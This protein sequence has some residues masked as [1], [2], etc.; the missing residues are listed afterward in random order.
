MLIGWTSVSSDWSAESTVSDSLSDLGLFFFVR[1]GFAFGSGF[2][3]FAVFRDF[4]SLGRFLDETVS[5]TD[6]LALK[7]IIKRVYDMAKN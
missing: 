1:F 7:Y 6:A 5:L 4:S 3:F 2:L